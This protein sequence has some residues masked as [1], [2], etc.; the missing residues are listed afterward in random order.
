[1]LL[2]VFQEIIQRRKPSS[3]F[4]GTL[5][6]K[7]CQFHCTFP[8]FPAW[9]R[10]NPPAGYYCLDILVLLLQI[11]YEISYPYLWR[12]PRQH[13][14]NMHTNLSFHRMCAPEYVWLVFPGP[15][16]DMQIFVLPTLHGAHTLPWTGF[17]VRYC[18]ML[19]S[20]LTTSPICLYLEGKGKG[21][22]RFFSVWKT[23]HHSPKIVEFLFF[24]PVS[25][26]QY[27]PQHAKDN[28]MQ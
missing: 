6:I 28:R 5:I 17:S 20:L 19:P 3:H 1:M 11:P 23:W 13:F 24:G 7:S 26:V 16:L 2:N 10:V 14:P 9:M 8:A 4:S 15:S 22:H 21:N 12:R 25:L 18:V 27:I